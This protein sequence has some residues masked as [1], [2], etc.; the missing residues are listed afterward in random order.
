MTTARC[1]FCME[2]YC[3]SYEITRLTT[4]HTRVK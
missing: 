4:A 2:T 1:F 3:F